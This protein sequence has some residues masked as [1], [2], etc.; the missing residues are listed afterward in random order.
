[1]TSSRSS[2]RL[3]RV[4]RDVLEL[5]RTGWTLEKGYEPSGGYLRKG[6]EAQRHVAWN[7]FDSLFEKALIMSDPDCY[8]RW[9]VN[10]YWIEKSGLVLANAAN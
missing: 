9:V 4:Q 1:M 10:E 7:T 3:T 2:Q 6:G 8:G 5:M